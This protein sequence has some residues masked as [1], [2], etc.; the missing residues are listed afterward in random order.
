MVVRELLARIG[1]QVDE[2]S[3]SKADKAIAGLK[4][5]LV[6]LGSAYAVK[7]AF[8]FVAQGFERI[9]SEADNLGRLSQKTGIAVEQLQALQFAAH[10]SDIESGTLEMGL[11]HLSRAA[12]EAATIGGAAGA[13]FFRLGVTVK[14]SDGH[15]KPVN[16][17]L[18][19][20]ADKFAKMPDGAEKADAAVQIFSRSGA[21][22]IPLLNGGSDGLARMGIEAKRAGVVMS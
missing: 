8:D 9:S 10:M 14:G 15:L 5:G 1:V 4:A 7:K 13:A 20:L 17:L 6:A 3:I 2:R 11:V 19:E 18:G 12:Q 22:L 16:A 21:E